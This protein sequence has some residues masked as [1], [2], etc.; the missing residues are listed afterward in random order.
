MPRDPRHWSSYESEVS[1]YF[2]HEEG[3]SAQCLDGTLGTATE[4][5]PPR[6]PPGADYWTM[7][8]CID[9]LRAADKHMPCLKRKVTEVDSEVV[10]DGSGG[11]CSGSQRATQRITGEYRPSASMVLGAAY[12][13]KA[14]KY[15]DSAPNG[16]ELLKQ[17]Q[18][19]YV[20]AALEVPAR[21]RP[22]RMERLQMRLDRILGR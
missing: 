2:Q 12:G 21:G 20:A 17:A 18:R 10:G 19:A 1:H 6:F 11:V 5:K 9:R 22:S 8:T 14:V 7:W 13:T 16:E 3:V 4:P 15:K